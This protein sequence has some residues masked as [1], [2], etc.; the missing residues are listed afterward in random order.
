MSARAMA[1]TREAREMG[2][3]IAGAGAGLGRVQIGDRRSSDRR[4]R[5]YWPADGVI[6]R[7]RYQHTGPAHIRVYQTADS[8]AGWLRQIITLICV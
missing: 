6:A 7:P 8:S 4:Y 3:K 2:V 1:G 5:R